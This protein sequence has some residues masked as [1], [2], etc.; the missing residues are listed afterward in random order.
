MTKTDYATA[1][2]SIVEAVGGA[3][4]VARLSHCATR[5]RFVLKDPGKADVGR[6]KGIDGVDRLGVAWFEAVPPG[7]ARSVP[8]GVPSEDRS[9]DESDG[10]GVA[11]D[12]DRAFE[13]IGLRNPIG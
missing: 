3:D 12:E 5:L 13:S 8:G 9:D 11:P 10:V 6:L 2:P 4:N 1:A 7:I